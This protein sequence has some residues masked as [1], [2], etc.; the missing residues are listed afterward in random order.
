MRQNVGLEVDNAIGPCVPPT[1][2]ETLR[3]TRGEGE[4]GED[5]E[6]KEEEKDSL[7][8]FGPPLQLAGLMSKMP[9]AFVP[10]SRPYL[11]RG[12]LVG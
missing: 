10:R 1:I 3:G 5:A 8:G 9:L 11:F 6:G 12:T 7:E 2:A 4:E